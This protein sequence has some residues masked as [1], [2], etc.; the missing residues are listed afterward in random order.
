MNL[1]QIAGM[2]IGQIIRWAFLWLPILYAAFRILG[3][4]W[5]DIEQKKRE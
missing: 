4:C 2:D 3:Y 5:L 1:L